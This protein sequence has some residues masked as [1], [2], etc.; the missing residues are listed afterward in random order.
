[1]K[2]TF[3]GLLSTMMLTLAL[4]SCGNGSAVSSSDVD[5]TA[6]DTTIV[7]S[8]DTV[9]VADTTICVE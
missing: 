6:V 9:A 5:T 4:G 2:K 3:F 8:I 7:D 1:M